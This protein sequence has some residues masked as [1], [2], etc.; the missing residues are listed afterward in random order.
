VLSVWADA[1]DAA[2]PKTAAH[3]TRTTRLF[4]TDLP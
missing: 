2:S 1:A 3:T 4:I